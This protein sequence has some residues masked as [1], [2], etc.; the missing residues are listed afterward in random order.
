MAQELRA[1]TNRVLKCVPSKANITK[2][3]AKVLKELR[4]D[5]D[6]IILTADKW[7]TMVVL[8]R[9]DYINKGMDFL[10]ER[11]THILLTANINNKYK[12]RLTNISGLLGLKVD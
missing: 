10:M 5:R 12:N 2:D 3:E 9:Q 1:G 4:K 6:R 11:D 8:D 7:V